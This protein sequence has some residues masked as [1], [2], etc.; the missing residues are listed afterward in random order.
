MVARA[1]AHADAGYCRDS[2]LC[3][4]KPTAVYGN[5]IPTPI[6][7]Q[8]VCCVAHSRSILDDDDLE[9]AF[10]ASLWTING[11]VV[12]TPSLERE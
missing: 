8:C 6:I 2:L 10:R 1:A 4:R 7:H 5:V 9:G 3:T 11:D 12:R